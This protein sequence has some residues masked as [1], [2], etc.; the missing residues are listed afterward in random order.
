MEHITKPPR[1]TLNVP[2]TSEGAASFAERVARKGLSTAANVLLAC[3]DGGDAAR[4]AEVLAA[5]GFSGEVCVVEGGY[6]AWSEIFS[7]SGRR[8]PPKGRWVA[9]GTEALKSGL[10]IPGVAE[11]YTEG[12]D[13]SKARYVE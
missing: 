13:L 2:W 4:A 6:D 9:S 5:A 12:G 11:S 10:N 3:R 7:T 8:K 1:C